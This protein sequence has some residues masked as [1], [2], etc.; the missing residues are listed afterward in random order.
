[1]PRFAA[2]LGYLFTDRPLLERIDAAA[3]SGFKAI[4]LQFPYD[5]PASQ[6]K[7]AIARNKLTVLG[8][9]TPPGARDGEFG[10][11]AIP[12]R[13]K[14]FQEVVRPRARLHFD[15]R[16]QR[17]ALPRRQGRARAAAGGRAR[18]HRQ[19]QAGR[20]SRRGA[21]NQ[22]ADRA[23]QRHRP[24]G[25]LSQPRRARRRRHR[26]G[27]QAEHPHAVRLLSRADRRRRHR[28]P[29]GE[30]HCRSSAICNAPRCPRG[31]SRTRARSIILSCSRKWTGWA[32]P[33]GLVQNTGRDS[34]P[35]RV[36]VGPSPTAWCRV[37]HQRL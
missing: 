29:A 17:G 36:W 28:P 20:R 31:T 26:Q 2:N 7:A 34:A 22:S 13:E 21:Q 4:E 11:A 10:L 25:L 14:E 19:P 23:D 3:A 16:R 37:N 18:V 15:D 9:N 27:G 33:A 32:M 24:A 30:I 8:I 1:M 35:K 12:G 5:V 6:V